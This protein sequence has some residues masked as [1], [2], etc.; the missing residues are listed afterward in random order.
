M[1]LIN[2]ALYGEGKRNNRLLAEYIYCDHAQE[3]SAY[4]EG[5]CLNVT[6]PFNRRCE[7]G[8]VEKVDGG[9]KQSKRY[10]TV[11]DAARH[12]PEYRKLRYPSYWYVIRIGDM[13]YLNLPYVDLKLDGSRLNASTAIFTN[14]H[15]L[16]EQS[17]LTPE[18][19]DSIL[20]YNPRNMCGDIITR[21]ADET[22]PNFLHQFKRL[23]PVEYERFVKEYPKYAEISPTF[24]GRYAKL[25]TCNP[26]CVY[27]DSSGDKFTME[28]GK[29]MV[30]KE[31]KSGFLPF[32]AS[33]AEVVITLT[34]N[35]TVKIT[36]NAQVL[37]DTVFV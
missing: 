20:G 25:A 27:K 17:L 32:G 18:N 3:C 37:D 36:D 2:V 12:S 31:Y 35:M 21:Y 10:D 7:L 15:L 14:D 19:L 29:R 11:T 5:K 4:H 26:D 1:P 9:T 23:F 24:I 13:A 34:D 8:R 22:V 28:D 33:K 6:I 30:C 16:V